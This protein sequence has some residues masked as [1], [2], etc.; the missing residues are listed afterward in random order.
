MGYRPGFM[1]GPDHFAFAMKHFDTACEKLLFVGDSRHDAE[2]A[3]KAGIR[4]IARTGLHSR[5]DLESMLPGIE[6]VENLEQLLPL[7]GINMAREGRI[8]QASSRANQELGKR[9]TTL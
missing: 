1:K 9:S 2:S 7:V 4:F 3:E 8:D 5:S 6:V